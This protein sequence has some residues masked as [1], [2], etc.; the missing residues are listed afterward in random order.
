MMGRVR[1][2]HDI[3]VWGGKLGDTP[4]I[5]YRVR[6]CH[7]VTVWCG[8]FNNLKKNLCSTDIYRMVLACPK[9]F[10]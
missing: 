10:A 1:P 9:G 5:M 7:D 2:F 8:R 3:K 6:P 4:N